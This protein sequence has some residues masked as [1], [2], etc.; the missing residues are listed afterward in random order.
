[1]T[2]KLFYLVIVLAVQLALIPSVASAA[3]QGQGETV[4]TVQKDDNLWS[5]GEKYL[6]N[7][8][9]YPA[10]VAATNAKHGTDSSFARIDNPSLIQPG[11]KILVPSAEEAAKFIAEAAAAPPAA[12]M[13]GTLRIGIGVEPVTLDPHHYKAAG[14]DFAVLDLVTDGLVA[15][16]RNLNLVPQLATSWEWLD[17]TTLRFKLRQ[18]VVFQDDTPWNAEAAKVNFDRIATAAEMKGH[19][20]HIA[21]CDVVDDYTIVLK[22]ESRFSP[23]LGNLAAPIGGMLSPAAIENLGDEIARKPVGTGPYKLEEWLPKERLVLVKNPTYWGTPFKLDKLIFRPFP[24]EA[25]RL[26]AFQAGELDVIQN[27]VPSSVKT[28]EKDDRFQVVR[29]TQMRNLW[30]GIIHGDETLDNLKLRQAIAYAINRD[31]LVNQVAEGMADVAESLIPPSVMGLPKV[32]YP[33]DP[34]KAKQLL[35]EA[36]YPQGLKLGLWVSQGRYLKD[37]EI[38]EAIQ[39]Q[40]KEVGID[41]ELHIVEFG[42]LVKVASEH[43]QQLW[44]QGWGLAAGDPDGMRPLMYSDGAVNTA[45]LKDP[46]VDEL[47]DKGVAAVSEEERKAIYAELEKLVVQDLVTMVPIYFEVGFY[48]TTT[49][50]HDFYPHPLELIDIAQT[51][52]E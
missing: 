23:L 40:L 28:L 26:L 1:M 48:A 39:A 27:P 52:I 4:Y 25:T 16:D 37:K 35:A 13:G 43:E 10:I 15:F 22:L 2:K 36:G 34:A 9:A 49:K 47:F 46:R 5:V 38:G 33:Y 21:S 51:W 17:N 30:L 8:A 18:G 41:A 6:G 20:G 50:V 3:P 31:A 11:W 29:T 42:T 32:A 7:G 14:I 44:L 12:K 24:E 45:N 19:Y